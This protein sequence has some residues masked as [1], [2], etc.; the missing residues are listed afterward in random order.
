M[1][2]VLKTKARRVLK[3]FN[4]YGFVNIILTIYVIENEITFYNL[5]ELEQYFIDILKPNLNVDLIARGS[6]FHFPMSEENKIKLRKARGVKIYIYCIDTLTLLYIFDS[7]QDLINQ[8]KIHHTTLKNCLIN[9]T[10]Y[11]DKILFCIELI[12]EYKN[13]SKLLS[14]TE[15]TNLIQNYR[16]MYKKTHPFNQKILAE[17]IGN[18][19]FKKEFPSL[20]SLSKYLKGDRATI[21]KYLISNEKKLYRGK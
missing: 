6:G 14:L 8:L 13:L 12:L 5:I 17:F 18:Y 10:K 7:K 11:L 4:K 1:L 20:T 16:E 21:K 19:S 9:G 3:Y 2:S 15:I